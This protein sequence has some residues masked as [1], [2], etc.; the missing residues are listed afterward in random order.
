MLAIWAW[1]LVVL[2]RGVCEG[3]YVAGV[4]Y[5]DLGW[6]WA[7]APLLSLR[8]PLVACFL[9]PLCPYLHVL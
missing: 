2:S 1:V 5:L 6:V 7:V 8:A 3:L 9:G 4:G